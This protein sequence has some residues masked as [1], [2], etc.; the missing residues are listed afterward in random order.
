MASA[1]IRLL[2]ET[3]VVAT[4]ALLSVPALLAQTPALPAVSVVAFEGVSLETGEIMADELAARLVDTGRFRVL[5]REWLP[6]PAGAPRPGIGAL[7]SAAASVGVE[8]LLLGRAQQ[9][10]TTAFTRP[11]PRGLPRSGPTFGPVRPGPAPIGPVALPAAPPPSIAGLLA[12]TRPTR[13]SYYSVSVWVI[14]I[15][16]GDVVRTAAAQ[17]RFAKSRSDG[18]QQPI[19]ELARTIDLSNVPR[20]SGDR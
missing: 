5:T 14:A 19:A 10:T 11:M 13:Q 9:V 6:R 18:W 4:T 3:A 8:Y 1:P 17:S 16:T 2:V 15:D 7:R 20:A 12:T